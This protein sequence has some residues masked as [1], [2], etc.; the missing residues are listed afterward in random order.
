MPK[1]RLNEIKNKV[2]SERFRWKC[3]RNGCKAEGR[4]YTRK[5]AKY[6]LAFHTAMAHGKDK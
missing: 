3:G 6:A 1:K 5:N 4:A 2:V